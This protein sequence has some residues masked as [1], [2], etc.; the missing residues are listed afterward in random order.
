MFRLLLLIG[1]FFAAGLTISAAVGSQ[2]HRINFLD[3]PAGDERKQAFI[4]HLKPFIDEINQSLLKDRA[5][6][7]RLNQKDKLN[8]REQRW[9]RNVVYLYN[10]KNFDVSEQHHWAD[11]ID[12]VDIIPNSLALAQGA[13]ESGWGSSRF[14]R[15][16]NNYFGQWCYKKGCGL[17]PKN[18]IARAQHEV[19]KYDSIQ[20]SVESYINNLNKHAAYKKLREIRVQ[21]RK[22]GQRL[23]GHQL[24][25]GLQHYSERGQL[26]VEEIQALIRSNKLDE[27]TT[28]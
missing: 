24:A 17:I 5:K 22:N 8:I 3:Y 26:Y 21:L 2:Q 27:S 20:D 4:A 19:A 28:G 9:L 6:L 12:K 16:G 25:R 13:K 14:A 10:I 23:T 15:E 7:I 1:S 18:R 11:L